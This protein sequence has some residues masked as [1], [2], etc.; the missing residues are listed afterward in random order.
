[1]DAAEKLF[2]YNI[3]KGLY[4]GYLKA[5]DRADAISLLTEAF[6][7]VKEVDLSEDFEITELTELNNRSYNYPIKTYEDAIMLS[8]DY[9]IIIS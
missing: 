1:M 8:R 4:I 2:Y 9:G 6:A 5:G 3:C 7:R